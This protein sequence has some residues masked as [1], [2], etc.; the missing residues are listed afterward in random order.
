MMYPI[1][2]PLWFRL[3]R[4]EFTLYDSARLAVDPAALESGSPRLEQL[5][6]AFASPSADTLAQA[7]ETVLAECRKSRY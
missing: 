2:L 1:R 4:C 5:A 7:H 6:A 3:A